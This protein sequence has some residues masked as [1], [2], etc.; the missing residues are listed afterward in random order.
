MGKCYSKNYI[1]PDNIHSKNIEFDFTTIRRIN[2]TEDL[3]VEK[4]NKKRI[5]FY[6]PSD[7]KLPLEG[8]IHHCMFC[9][10]RTSRN[11]FYSKINNKKIYFQICDKCWK[12]KIN[13]KNRINL[14]Y[15]IS[16]L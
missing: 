2:D 5:I 4:T 3:Y 16:K 15:I 8:W 14:E 7:T 10:I 13:K 1:E 9:K 6:Y 12:N 11:Q